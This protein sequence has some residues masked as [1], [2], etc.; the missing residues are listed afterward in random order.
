MNAKMSRVRR[1]IDLDDDTARAVED[2][3]RDRAV[4]VNE[5]AT[6]LIRRGLQRVSKF[7]QRTR[8]LGLQIGVSC[9][10]QALETLEHKQTR[11]V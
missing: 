3:C 6:E 9:V 4:G 5:A 10:A 11:P 7:K 2:Y 8:P 1:V